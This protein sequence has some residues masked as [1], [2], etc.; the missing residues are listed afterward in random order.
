MIKSKTI[1]GE[2]YTYVLPMDLT[3]TPYSTKELWQVRP[4]LEDTEDV[5]LVS[6]I[7]QYGV[8]HS[9]TI[10]EDCLCIK[11]FPDGISQQ[12]LPYEKF[13]REGSPNLIGLLHSA[14]D[15]D[16]ES[17]DF[18]NV[19]PPTTNLKIAVESALA[20]EDIFVIYVRT[21]MNDLYSALIRGILGKGN[22]WQAPNETLEE[23]KKRLEESIDYSILHQIEEIKKSFEEGPKDASI[24]ID[25]L[26]DAYFTALPI[27]GREGSKVINDAVSALCTRECEN[28]N[29]SKVAIAAFDKVI[30]YVGSEIESEKSKFLKQHL[31]DVPP[32]EMH[33]RL[34]PY[35]NT[36]PFSHNE[37]V[38]INTDACWEADEMI[39]AIC[40]AKRLI[41]LGSHSK[42]LFGMFLQVAAMQNK[43]IVYG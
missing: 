16:N 10:K 14:G 17:K 13:L 21:G 6:S 36:V 38:I 32:K 30:S 4:F 2:T 39:E 5:L 7:I 19:L 9:F 42:G 1:D 18:Y 43:G 37:V 22:D 20:C 27:M 23:Y 8:P 11:T 3:N 34:N 29:H 24:A 26:K 31:E 35:D 12:L 15:I 41:L 33:K 25:L 40:Y 28:N